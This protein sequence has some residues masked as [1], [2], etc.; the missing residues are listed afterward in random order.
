MRIIQL[1]L[2]SVALI[3]PGFAHAAAAGGTHVRAVLVIASN[4]KSSPD[5]KLEAYYPTLRRMLRFD[6]YRFAGEG[7]VTVAAG[8]KATVNLGR[9]HS[10]ALEN[11]RADAGGV[12]L[13]VA[14]Q[15]GGR[16]LINT[17]ISQKAGVPLVLGGPG[18]GREGEAWA[19][20]VIAE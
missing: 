16:M 6:S 2:L 5:P 20:I 18:T 4:D 19:V 10:L 3:V 12:R 17:V 15:E 9:G 1:I 11:Q 13:Q 14:W 7:A 8:G